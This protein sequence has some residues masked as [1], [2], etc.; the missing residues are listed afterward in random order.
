MRKPSVVAQARDAFI[1]RNAKAKRKKDRVKQ[2][3]IAREF[4][5]S[6]SALNHAL[7]RRANQEKKKKRKTTVRKKAT[8]V[9]KPEGGAARNIR[10]GKQDLFRSDDALIPARLRSPEYVLNDDGSKQQLRSRPEERRKQ[11]ETAKKYKIKMNQCAIEVQDRVKRARI[12]GTGES[13]ERI[14]KK[15]EKEMGLPHFL[16]ASRINTYVRK[17][18]VHG[19]S[20]PL[21]KRGRQTKHTQEDLIFAAAAAHLVQAKQLAVE[22]ITAAEFGDTLQRAFLD[23]SDTAPSPA[24]LLRKFIAAYPEHF[25]F[26][27][28]RTSAVSAAS[29]P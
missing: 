27:P 14:I 25:C 10:L 4:N 6:Q 2:V 29:I 8:A 21:Q 20:I 15:A 1:A 17:T 24:A 3:T 18:T 23:V 26:E 28:K 5:V 11:L 12:A 7:T 13:T 16:N 19:P 22:T 9:H